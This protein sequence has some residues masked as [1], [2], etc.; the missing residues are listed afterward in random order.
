MNDS[1]LKFRLPHIHRVVLREFSLFNRATEI[2]LDVGG[3]VLC[4]AGAN[5]LGKS[6][7]VAA[8]N[9]GLT[10]RVPEPNRTFESVDEYFRYTEWFSSRYFDGRIRESQR[11]LAEI[12]LEFSIGPKRFR[13]VR[14]MFEPS[15]LRFLSVQDNH[16][17]PLDLD[18]TTTPADLH[19]LFCGEVT[20]AAGLGNFQQFVFLQLFLLTFDERRSLVFWDERVLERILFLAFGL[21]PAAAQIAD[22]LRRREARG[23]SRSRNI[24]W[25][26]TR[27]RARIK[28]L[29]G[30]MEVEEADDDLVNEHQNLRKRCDEALAA[31]QLFESELSDTQLHIE[32]LTAKHRALRTEFD[33]TFGARTSGLSS[34]ALYPAIVDSLSKTNCVVCGR[35]DEGSLTAI[36][37]IVAENNCPLCGF[38]PWTR[39]L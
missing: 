5:G 34:A 25:E 22:T 33:D 2:A 36:E 11:G 27:T 14:G 15:E 32:N 16:G 28:D 30:Y 3:G 7:F 12:E 26:I 31:L 20:R 23:D 35:A 8:V 37:K 10:G 4:L 17:Q 6:T 29:Q 21:D 39:R 13:I 18:L 19:D 24:Q 1:R 38:G 9:F